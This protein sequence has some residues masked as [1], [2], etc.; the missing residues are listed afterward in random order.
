M[1]DDLFYALTGSS[2][3]VLSASQIKI[4]AVIGLMAAFGATNFLAFSYQFLGWLIS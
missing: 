4:I 2:V 3:Y 1:I